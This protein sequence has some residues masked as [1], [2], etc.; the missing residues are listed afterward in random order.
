[1]FCSAC[2]GQLSLAPCPNC[3]AVN[4]VTASVCHACKAELVEP[5]VERASG[6]S[7][8]AGTPRD[9]GGIDTRADRNVTHAAAD[10]ALV[11]SSRET[12]V[13]NPDAA[14]SLE[15]QLERAKTAVERYD[16]VPAGTA[17]VALHGAPRIRS[18]NATRF[19][20][21]PIA[22]AA[23]AGVL[24]AIGVL[25]YASS[26]SPVHPTSPDGSAVP[27]ESPAPTESAAP[28]ERA[29]SSAAGG[30]AATVS[31]NPAACTDGVLALGLC[32]SEPGQAQ[33]AT[34][35]RSSSDVAQRSA[36]DD[37]TR[38]CNGAAAALGLC[39]QT[40]TTKGKN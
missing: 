31:D 18:R 10:G 12:G 8:D 34:R 33:S 21:R 11:G 13:G 39:A 25:L 28:A 14:A 29:G 20:P 40:I 30:A 24:I 17:V 2:G 1:M 27:T 22:A 36:K 32:P 16:A 37:A 6:G 3:E 19:I 23:G 7:E 9:P 15:L 35:I 38:E 4:D 26:R 5:A